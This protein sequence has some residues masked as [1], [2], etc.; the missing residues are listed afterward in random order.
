MTKSS[1]LNS[2]SDLFERSFVCAVILFS[3]LV[4]SFGFLRQGSL[5]WDT[6]KIFS[7]FRDNLQ[8][9]NTFG[10]IAYWF[11]HN[12]F[13]FP[14]YYHSLLGIPSLLSPAFVGIGF[15]VWVLGRCQIFFSH[16]QPIYVFYFAFSVPALFTIAAW[17]LSRRL[18]S[19]CFERAYIVALAA[20]SPSVLFN[21]TDVGYLEPTAYGLFFACAYLDFIK[22]ASSKTFWRMIL[23]MALVV[24]SFSHAALYWNLFAIPAFLFLHAFYRRGHGARAALHAARKISL[25]AWALALIALALVF[26]PNAIA[27]LQGGDL[28]RTSLGETKSYPIEKLAAGNA[29]ELFAASVPGFGF[30]WKSDREHW[31]L[32][33]QSSHYHTAYSYLG[34]FCLPLLLIGL[35]FGARRLRFSLFAFIA[36]F[37]AVIC[38][39][40]HSPLFTSI[41]LLL[42]PLRSCNHFSDAGFKA[43]SDLI[44]IFGAALGLEALRK[45]KHRLRGLALTLF[46]LCLFVAAWLWVAWF[47]ITVTER[48]EFGLL[49]TLGLLGFVALV[50]WLQARNRV[51][52]NRAVACVIALTLFDVSTNTFLYLRNLW[53]STLAFNTGWS[54]NHIVDETPAVDGVGL[55]DGRDRNYYMNVLLM[56]RPYYEMVRR[57]ISVETLPLAALFPSAHP[58]RSLESEFTQNSNRGSL[59]LAVEDEANPEFA[60]FFHVP[61]AQALRGT[62]IRG[63]S[64]S[65]TKWH[66]EVTTPIPTLLFLRDG[67]S[68]F[69][70]AK[71]N[72]K[73]VS[74]ARAY[75]NFKAVAVPGGTSEVEWEFVPFGIGGSALMAYCVIVFL[76]VASS[77]IVAEPVSASFLLF[78]NSIM[79]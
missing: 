46:S 79:G 77:L 35:L 17:Q 54:A 21:V 52:I 64:H 43:G 40:G 20:F 68:P 45:Q 8:A 62:S 18:F 33:P 7:E 9:L 70:K 38:L 6:A 50:W 36:L 73:N 71:V 12:Q 69:W 58:A 51:Q 13:G 2:R 61:A 31:A 65:F 37:F 59:P 57:G 48:M 22:E 75:F 24:L 30:D 26:L 74:V 27:Y 32:L 42:S 55:R 53:D 11:P 78:L 19:S 15:I 39:S 5:Y 47:Q 1:K 49:C 72:G 44:L 10:E 3:G 67:F 14:G 25:R 66:M 28:V 63:L 29:L 34:L 60:P 23:A 41:L 4:M 76:A 16:Y 56:Y